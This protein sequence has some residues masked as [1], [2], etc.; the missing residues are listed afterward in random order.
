METF[1]GLF[2]ASSGAFEFPGETKNS[3]LL[4]MHGP[5][6]ANTQLTQDGTWVTNRKAVSAFITSYQTYFWTE[7]WQNDEKTA[8]KDFAAGN[9]ESFESAE[10]AVAWLFGDDG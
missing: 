5:V 7:T 9:Y 8:D 2:F 4:H 6:Y 10:D 1:K 3:P